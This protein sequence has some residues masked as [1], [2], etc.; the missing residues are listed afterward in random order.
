MNIN[1]LFEEIQDEFILE[2]L[3]GEF[4]LQGRNIVW[5]YNLEDS[6]EEIDFTEDDEDN[7]F[8]FDSVS[9]EE[10]LLEGYQEDFEK[11]QNKLDEINES[12]NWKFGDT[13]INESIISFV[14]S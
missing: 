7:M 13:D 6:N 9:S 1:E 2:D 4:L 12:D 14:I 11:L 5:S 8:G 10:L 3:N